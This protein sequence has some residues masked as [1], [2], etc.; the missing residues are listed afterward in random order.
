MVVE[1]QYIRLFGNV[2]GIRF[3][4]VSELMILAWESAPTVDLAGVGWKVC[5][6]VRTL[7]LQNQYL[8]FFCRF[9][10]TI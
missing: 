8:Q 6:C 4:D 2:V 7:L 1:N 5:M 3:I 9:R 10:L